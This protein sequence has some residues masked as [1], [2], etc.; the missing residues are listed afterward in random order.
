MENRKWRVEVKW[1]RLCL[2]VCMFYWMTPDA[3]FPLTWKVQECWERPGCCGLSGIFVMVSEKDTS[4]TLCEVCYFQTRSVIIALWEQICDNKKMNKNYVKTYL[5]YLRQ[6]GNTVCHRPRHYWHATQYCAVPYI[7][8]PQ[9]PVLGH[10]HCIRLMWSE[11][12]S[13]SNLSALAFSAL[14][15]LV[16]RQEWHPVCNKNWMLVCWWW[17]FDWSFARL[18]APVVQ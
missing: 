4:S 18:I 1:S 12:I 11:K 15:L 6:S 8:P 14:T 2:S 3:G 16:G 9:R 17:W 13:V 7:N 10:I 5:L